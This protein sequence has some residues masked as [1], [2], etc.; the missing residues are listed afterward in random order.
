MTIEEKTELFNEETFNIR[1]ESN[2]SR[3][4]ALQKVQYTVLADLM[5]K[6]FIGFRFLTKI[7]PLH[8]NSTS[9]LPRNTTNSSP[10]NLEVNLSQP[11][12]P[13]QGTQP[14]VEKPFIF[15]SHS[16]S[17]QENNLTTRVHV[18]KPYFINEQSTLNMVEILKKMINRYIELISNLVENKERFEDMVDRVCHSIGIDIWMCSQTFSF[19]L[20]IWTF[21][22]AVGERYHHAS[23]QVSLSQQNRTPRL[24]QCKRPHLSDIRLL[25]II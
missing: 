8:H 13:S 3:F 7:F 16:S 22:D 10:D 24:Q 14:Q 23:L 17:R 18:E 20:C 21:S 5:A 1:S 25:N 15:T 6:N 4:H 2:S 9:S 12:S 19:V 11:A